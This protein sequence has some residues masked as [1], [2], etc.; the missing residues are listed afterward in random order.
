MHTANFLAIP[1]R[2][3]RVQTTVPIL[4]T[5]LDGTH[6]S[7]VCE[8]LVVNAHGCA[9]LSRMKFVAGAP[10]HFHSKE[11]RQTTAHVVSCEAVG[12]SNQG[13]RLGAKLDRP[14]NFWGLQNCPRDWALPAAPPATSL[15]STNAGPGRVLINVPRSSL[16]AIGPVAP[17]L[18][19][20]MKKMIAE[21]VRPLQE[22]ITALKQQL[23][24]REAN[25]SRFE[26]SLSSI[27][28]DLE[29]QLEIRLRRYLGP[30]LIE[31]TRQESAHVIQAA[32]AAIEEKTSQG[33]ESF[34]RR[35]QEELTILE[36]RAEDISARISA[37]AREHL[38]GGLDAF[39]QRLVEGGN[40][41]KRLSEELF[42]YLQHN[43]KEEHDAAHKEL[44][45]LRASVA[46]QS[47]RLHEHID[48]LDTRIV[49]L[50][51]SAH[52]VESG[53][54]QRLTQLASEMVNL[55]R[56][57]LES[58]ASEV[59]EQRMQ[60]AVKDFGNQLQAAREDLKMI[61]AGIVAY[62]SEALKSQSAEALQS[63]VRSV[64]E[65][66]TD[67]AD[68]WR[69]QLASRLNALAKSIGE[70]FQLAPESGV[71]GLPDKP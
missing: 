9:I 28:P 23:A 13:W 37:S 41:L 36:K 10:L 5:S 8:T 30:R 34:L 66:A 51:E 14:E 64:E 35:S 68:R 62:V 18:E 3:S 12:P 65:L 56:T 67:C 40:A 53:L 31:E 20:H 19:V 48:Y 16:S 39:Q 47:A 25:P 4:V 29:H 70:Q 69:I 59:F 60:Q 54:D 21:S 42:S 71:E 7:E 6:F 63:F 32:T 11:G 27:P 52:A 45:Q 38:G 61:Q 55:T 2:S 43:L 24:Q 44:E 58:T 1:R 57:Q 17:H 26:V 22:E 46:S 15:P 49:K 33:Y 50:N